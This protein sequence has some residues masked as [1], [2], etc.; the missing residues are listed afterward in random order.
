M[1]H[2]QFKYTIIFLGHAPLKPTFIVGIDND[3]ILYHEEVLLAAKF[4]H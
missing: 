1:V 4:Q 3:H 2:N